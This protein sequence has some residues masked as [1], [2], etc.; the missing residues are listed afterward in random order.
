MKKS[1]KQGT[2]D[3]KE[4]GPFSS[5]VLFFMGCLG[6]LLLSCSGCGSRTEKLLQELE[7]T[8][9]AAG[10]KTEEPKEMEAGEPTQIP[11]SYIYVDV[12]GAVVS[13]GVYRM[14]DGDRVFQALE[15]AG[16][17]LPEAALDRVNQAA[18]VAD[19]QQIR[20]LTKE[21]AEDSDTGSKEILS[22][23]DSGGASSKVNLNT[24]DEAELCTLSGI[25]EAKAKAIIKYRESHGAFS[26]VE[27][28]MNVEGIKE[29]TY[30]KIE[31]EITVR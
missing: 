13:P 24:A 10:A 17:A 20:I 27:E 7:T 19:G 28:L 1:S 22:G 16:G 6:V 30:Q 9:E 5:F 11:E 21:E 14:Q 8:E 4:R 26:T 2:V 25:G 15:A 12:E 18:V 29:G 23:G 3:G 31:D